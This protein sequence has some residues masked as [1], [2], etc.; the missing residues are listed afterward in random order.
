MTNGYRSQRLYAL[1]GVTYNEWIGLGGDA[2]AVG[3][4]WLLEH[5]KELDVEPAD[6]AAMVN[7]IRETD[8]H[9]HHGKGHKRVMHKAHEQSKAQFERIYFTNRHVSDACVMLV[10]TKAPVGSI[11]HV[12]L[13]NTDNIT[14]DALLALCEEHGESLESLVLTTTP[15]IHLPEILHSVS[16]CHAEGFGLLTKLH[17]DD[18]K[19]LG[20]RQLKK[21]AAKLPKNLTSLSLK[22]GLNVE[23]A[24]VIEIA[25][26]HTHIM[27]LDLCGCEKLTDAS[28]LYIA[29]ACVEIQALDVTGCHFLTDECMVQFAYRTRRYYTGRKGIPGKGPYNHD[30]PTLVLADLVLKN[31]GKKKKGDEEDDNWVFDSD[32]ALSEDAEAMAAFEAERVRKGKVQQLRREIQEKE[33]TKTLKSARLTLEQVQEI[34]RTDKDD[35]ADPD[36]KIIDLDEIAIKMGLEEPAQRERRLRDLEAAA[37]AAAEKEA[38][39][40]CEEMVAQGLRPWQIARELN[41]DKAVVVKV[42]DKWDLKNKVFNTLKDVQQEDLAKYGLQIKIPDCKVKRAILK[43]LTRSAANGS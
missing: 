26:T 33:F 19:E 5:H 23:D 32:I 22:Y 11:K 2:E 35:D 14:G 13:S 29:H 20:D 41:L 15:K 25:K 42:K 1:A 6:I 7:L 18:I 38:M 28:I 36:A 12:D 16:L 37:E 40:K 43:Y 39:T 27:S 21:M 8:P 34:F 9:G 31:R 17:L 3:M 10:S 30:D 4:K 24:G